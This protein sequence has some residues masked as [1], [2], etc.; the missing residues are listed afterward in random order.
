M[1]QLCK[2]NNID[3]LVTYLEFSFDLFVLSYSVSFLLQTL[4]P[5]P[6]TRLL[7]NN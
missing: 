2:G 7:I 3:H 1:K 6:E 4:D 5:S